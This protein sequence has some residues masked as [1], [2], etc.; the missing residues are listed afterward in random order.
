MNVNSEKKIR[1]YMFLIIMSLCLL[2]VAGIVA[3][4]INNRVVDGKINA[5]Y[6]YFTSDKLTETQTTYTVNSDITSISFDIA[7]CA[8]EIRYSDIDINYTITVT[9]ENLL[10]F[11][12]AEWFTN[13]VNLKGI[14]NADITGASPWNFDGVVGT[15]I[16]LNNSMFAQGINAMTEAEALEAGYTVVK[17]AKEL[18]AALEAVEYT[19]DLNIMLFADIDMSEFDNWTGCSFGYYGTF[20]GNG[21]TISNLTGTNGLFSYLNGTVRNVNME[22]VNI[23]DGGGVGA[24]AE[25]HVEG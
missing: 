4:Y 17:T 5:P 7:N 20:D 23:S 21:Y 19:Y 15:S 8:D 2:L 9:G 12:D 25:N 1:T 6:F 22:N 14:L 16:E 10:A 24:I 18:Q 13:S 11:K 3:K